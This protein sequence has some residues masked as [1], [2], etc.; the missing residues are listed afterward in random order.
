MKLTK[1]FLG[2]FMTMMMLVSMMKLP[3]A[4][5][6]LAIT[7]QPKTSYTAYNETAK[8][9]IKATGD[10]DGNITNVEYYI[11]TK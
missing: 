10:G 6:T 4:A 8:A 3:V 5:A 9:T 7:T 1:K 2:V 11:V